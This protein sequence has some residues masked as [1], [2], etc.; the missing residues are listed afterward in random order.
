MGARNLDAGAN[1]EQR[2]KMD[3]KLIVIPAVTARLERRGS[4][5]ARVYFPR[6]YDGHYR[7]DYRYVG[8]FRLE[9]FHFSAR[10]ECASLARAFRVSS[11]YY[12]ALTA[13]F[14]KINR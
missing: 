4:S 9:G 11:E 1:P 13:F 3:F 12:T 7:L 2:A 8:K 10:P 5:F 6:G 14:I